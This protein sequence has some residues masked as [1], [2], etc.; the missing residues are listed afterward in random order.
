M[1]AG[2]ALGGLSDPLAVTLWYA[3]SLGSPQLEG[4]CTLPALLDRRWTGCLTGLSG[5]DLE[6]K[7]PEQRSA[8]LRKQSMQFQSD[9]L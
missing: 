5:R 9:L 8:P 4:T 2:R 7:F 6:R 3:G 1:R